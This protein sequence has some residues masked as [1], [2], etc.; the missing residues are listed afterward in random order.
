MLIINIIACRKVGLLRDR[1]SIQIAWSDTFMHLS[2]GRYCI[3][4]HFFLL[5][6][7]TPHILPSKSEKLSRLSSSHHSLMF[8]LVQECSRIDET[9]RLALLAVLIMLNHAWEEIGVVDFVVASE[10]SLFEMLV[11]LRP[12]RLVEKRGLAQSI[13]LF[14]KVSLLVICHICVFNWKEVSRNFCLLLKIKKVLDTQI[15]RDEKLV[16]Q[17]FIYAIESW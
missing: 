8:I 11:L 7:S 10:D 2:F 17:S 13:K 4:W 15:K 14:F 1:W 5:S 9:I 12:I 16:W 6:A 3:F